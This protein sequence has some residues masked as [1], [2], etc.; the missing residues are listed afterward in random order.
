MIGS[1][2]TLCGIG[3]L[4][5]STVGAYLLNPKHN[6]DIEDKINLCLKSIYVFNEDGSKMSSRIIKKLNDNNYLISIPV[7]KS[8]QDV[9]KTIEPIKAIIGDGYDVSLE[10]VD[11][12]VALLKLSEIHPL[13]ELIPYRLSNK[14]NTD[15][16]VIDLGEDIDGNIVSIDLKEDCHS[17]IVGTTGSGKSNQLRALLLDLIL[18]YNDMIE[19]YM[20]DMKIVELALFKN[21]R[22]CERFITDSDDVEN[23]LDDLLEEAKRRNQLFESLDVVDI[24]KYNKRIGDADTLKY[25]VIVIEEYA[26]LYDNKRAIKKLKKLIAIGRSVGIFIILTVQRC[27]YDILDNFIKANISNRITLRTMDSKNSIIAIDEPGAELLNNGE[28]L[29]RVGSDLIKYKAYYLST[30]KLKKMLEPFIVKKEPKE[31]VAPKTLSSNKANNVSTIKPT[32]NNI[33]NEID[34]SFLDKL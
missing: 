24:Y 19:L 28:V 3:S 15:S 7:S 32:D 11:S 12:S 8:V 2:I 33:N 17:Y 9:Q 22:C 10:L 4:A 21:C 14:A 25:K 34:I 5:I 6:N 26:M 23:V 20:V 27:S 29:M 31:E 30:E 1:I 13:P 16:L 18:K